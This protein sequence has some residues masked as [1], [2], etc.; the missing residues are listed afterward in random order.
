M[1][2]PHPPLDDLYSLVTRNEVGEDGRVCEA[3]DWQKAHTVTVAEA[4]PMMTINAAYALFRDE[5]VGSL[6]PGKYADLIVV[7][8]NPMAIEPEGIRELNVAL[9]MI[10]GRVV[11]CA[12]D[13]RAFCP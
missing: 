9:T 2:R 13:D 11:Y 1:V 6:E 4:L 8:G 7:T 5:E 10:G 12:A 3:P